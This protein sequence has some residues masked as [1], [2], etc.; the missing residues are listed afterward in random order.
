[1][2]SSDDDS[3]HDVDDARL[4]IRTAIKQGA[5]VIH[6]VGHRNGGYFRGSSLAVLEHASFVSCHLKILKLPWS[7]TTS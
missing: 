1:M 6:L 7:M 4:W 3:A 5:R 2:R